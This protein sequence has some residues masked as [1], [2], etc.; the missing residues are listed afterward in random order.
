MLPPSPAVVSILPLSCQFLLI[1]Y[2]LFHEFITGEKS[3]QHSNLYQLFIHIVLTRFFVVE[4]INKISIFHWKN[5]NLTVTLLV[6]FLK[7]FIKNLFKS[8]KISKKYPLK[9]NNKYFIIVCFINV[10]IAMMRRDRSKTTCRVKL[11]KKSFFAKKLN[12]HENI[13]LAKT[14]KKL[15]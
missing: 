4:I 12:M 9:F 1:F 6:R 2:A 7:I 5:I 15:I 13:Y 10:S 14:D 3:V 8:C 11:L